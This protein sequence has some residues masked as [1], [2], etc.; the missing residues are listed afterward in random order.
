[1]TYDVLDIG[2]YKR[3]FKYCFIYEKI[4][5]CVIIIYYTVKL[6]FFT[7]NPMVLVSCM[8]NNQMPY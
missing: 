4:K 1:M 2:V 8:T 5:K 7:T 3:N 6:L